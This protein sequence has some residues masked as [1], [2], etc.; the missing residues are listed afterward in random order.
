MTVC[1]NFTN[2]AD[3]GIL[4]WEIGVNFSNFMTLHGILNN[5]KLLCGRIMQ[6][7]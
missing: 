1:R 3:F 4:G 5:I 2:L 7:E 6:T